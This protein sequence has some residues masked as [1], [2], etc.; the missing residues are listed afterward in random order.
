MNED[1]PDYLKQQLNDLDSQITQATQLLSDPSVSNLAEEEIKKL[2]EEKLALLAPFQKETVNE[3][4]NEIDAQ[5]N[6]KNIILEI[7]GAAGGDEAKIWGEDLLRM[8]MKFAQ[9]NG[10]KVEF[11]DEMAIKISGKGAYGKLKYES[12]VH[13]VQRVP[14][15]E[16]SGRVHTSTATVAV[17]PEL[18][19]VDVHIEAS[20]LAWEFYRSGGKGGQNVNKVS[21]AVR[22]KHVPTDLVVTAQSER[23]Q[24]QN[25]DLALEKLR[26]ILWER[27]QMR[28]F[29]DLSAERKAQVGTGMRNE[30]IRTYNFLQDR[31]TDHRID[32]NFH[33]IEKFMQGN[34]TELIDELLKQYTN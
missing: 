17:L 16:N 12:G 4:S 8:Y 11:I 1:I 30:K 27:E 32:H 25:R 10:W 14:A 23:S 31:I 26:G 33:N 20:D 28:L 15:T 3:E 29:G 13:R 18:Q 19:D 24:E 9:L 2:E 6:R 34:I 21:T 7:R 22:L 5:W